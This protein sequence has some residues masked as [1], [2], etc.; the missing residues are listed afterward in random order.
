VLMLWFFISGLIVL[1]GAEL[2][3]ELEAR[4]LAHLGHNGRS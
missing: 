1:F 3:A 2:N 4:D